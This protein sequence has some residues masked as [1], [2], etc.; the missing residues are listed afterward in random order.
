MLSKIMIITIPL[1]SKI[2]IYN[3]KIKLAYIIF[4]DS[5]LNC[6]EL[7]LCLNNWKSRMYMILDQNFVF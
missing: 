3:H 2:Y 7:Q 6:K 5:I 4:K 1:E